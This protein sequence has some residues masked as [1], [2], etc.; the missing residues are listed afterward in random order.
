MQCSAPIIVLSFSGEER[1]LQDKMMGKSDSF[2]LVD[3]PIKIL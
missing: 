3:N 2:G 1:N